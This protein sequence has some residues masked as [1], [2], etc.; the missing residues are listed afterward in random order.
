MNF[1]KSK[2]EN[3]NSSINEN[4][5]AKSEGTFQRDFKVLKN[6]TN[7]PKKSKIIDMTKLIEEITKEVEKEKKFKNNDK[8]SDFNLKQKESTISDTK[9]NKE[10]FDYKNIDSFLESFDYGKKLKSK[11][12]KKSSTPDEFSLSKRDLKINDPV[13]NFLNTKSE[14]LKCRE[15][16][17]SLINFQ[18]IMIKYNSLK[19]RVKVEFLPSSIHKPDILNLKAF[20]SEEMKERFDEYL[21]KLKLGPLAQFLS[22]NI[23][24]CFTLHTEDLTIRNKETLDNYYKIIHSFQFDEKFAI[25]E[26]SLNDERILIMIESSK[27]PYSACLPEYEFFIISVN[28]SIFQK[29]NEMVIDKNVLNFKIENIIREL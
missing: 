3:E 18:K 16:Q 26:N 4:N 22:E 7:N 5:N 27:F 1:L 17:I 20:C 19:A 21:S 9:D 28:K 2:R 14:F 29:K 11:K 13:Q 15:I 23:L 12:I 10:L 25:L 24:T 8:C 6:Q